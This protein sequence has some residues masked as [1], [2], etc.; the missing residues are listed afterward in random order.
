VELSG[1]GNIPASITPP[2]RTGVEW[3]TPE[4]HE[5]LGNVGHDSFGGKRTFD[6]VV[7][8]LRGGDMDLGELSLP[9]WDPDQRSY[10]VARAAL[11]TVHV[12]PSTAAPSASGGTPDQELLAGLPATRDVLEGTAP[13]HL[14]ADDRP[15]FWLLGV[16]AWPAA[17]G[18]AVAGRATGRRL[19]RAWRVRRASPATELRDRVSA[20]NTAST[21]GDAR[22]LDAAIAR[23]LE[24][25]TIVHAGVNVRG[26]V[27]DELARRLEG[28][29]VA[30]EAALGVAEI[31][32]ECEAARFSPDAADASSAR[33]RWLR[34][35]GVIRRLEKR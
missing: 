34:A 16:G 15:L 3:L 28:A 13:T 18:I 27:G 12:K 17:F 26:A 7:R 20:A 19:A 1:T 2:A 9:Y 32:R 6:Y 5:Q 31:L 14:H 23:A 24:T 33:D 4:V 8:V 29:G 25:A 35:Q 10:V 22:A 21:R 11:G 30:R